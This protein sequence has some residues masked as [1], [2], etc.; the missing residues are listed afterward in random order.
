[1]IKIILLS[2]VLMTPT[3]TPLPLNGQENF[4]KEK[5]F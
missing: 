5:I 3:E 2:L 4:L 1:M